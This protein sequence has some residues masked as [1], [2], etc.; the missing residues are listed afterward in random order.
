VKSRELVGIGIAEMVVRPYISI[1]PSWNL[2]ITVP[3]V[4][5][6]AVEAKELMVLP[7]TG[8]L[9]GANKPGRI[10]LRSTCS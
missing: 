10:K 5:A 2:T 4:E 1:H 6:E 7:E 3:S 9:L 8:V